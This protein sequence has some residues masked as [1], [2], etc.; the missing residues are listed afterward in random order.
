[1]DSD[2]TKEGRI[3]FHMSVNDPK[4]EK[5]QSRESIELRMMCLWKST[6]DADSGVNSMP[7]EE[8]VNRNMIKD[9]LQVA[10]EMG[11]SWLGASLA[12]LKGMFTS[13]LGL[14][15]EGNYSGE[16]G[17][18]LDKFVDS[19]NFFPGWPASGKTWAKSVMK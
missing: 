18:Y 17:D 19:I 14:K 4:V 6:T 2:W 10:E 16:P 13:L 8:S 12:S 7:T 9:P 3:C 5:Y 11:S 1:M 15:E